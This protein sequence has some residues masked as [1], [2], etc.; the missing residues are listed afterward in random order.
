MIP[1]PTST[2]KG[3][4]WR[5]LRFRL[6]AWNALVVLLTALVTL[7][8]LRQGV[9]WTLLHELDQILREDAQ[10]VL[11][12]LRELN[13]S[14][15]PVLTEELARKA[16]GHRQH[17]WFVELRDEQGAVVW[18]SLRAPPEHSSA[19]ATLP[20]PGKAEIRSIEL[21]VPDHGVI[22]SVRVGAQLDFLQADMTRLDRLVFTA[23]AVVLVAAPLCGYWLARRAARTIGEIIDTAARLRPSRLE[24][25]LPVQGTDDE[26]DHLALTVNRL[27][28]R[29]A[30]YLQQK[31]DLLANA[32]HELRT[33]LAAIRSSVEVALAGDRSPREY[34]ELLE[35][36]IEQGTALET[37]VNQLLLLSETETEPERLQ[38]RSEQVPWDEVV[39]RSVEMFRGVAEARG[40]TLAAARLDRAT[41]S[42]NRQHLRQVVNN[43]LD[44]AVKYTPAGGTIDVSLVRLPEQRRTRLTIADSGVGI[45]PE[46]LPHVFDRFFRADRSRM[47]D[48]VAS[49]SGLGLSICQAV[50]QAH[51]GEIRCDSVL[52]AGTT[53]TVVLPCAGQTETSP[54]G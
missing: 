31:R 18:S 8:G 45:P 35:D 9:Q 30:E 48:G 39:A 54:S 19:S 7:V 4:P 42:G 49:G 21:A 53:M 38:V 24:E 32:A 46:D 29:V 15:F 51:G 40:I 6:A 41:V 16:I 14:E 25:R 28:D 34:Q 20:A 44:N 10:E 1:L 26:L 37:L 2:T 43:L 52:G 36:I 50:V 12:A 5:T 13:P 3:K 27:L 33:P 17:G 23:A 47:R 11:L 22:R